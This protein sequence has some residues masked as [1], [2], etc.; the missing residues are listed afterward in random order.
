ML[1][2]RMAHLL[3]TIGHPSDPAADMALSADLLDEVARGRRGPTARL[4]T[5]GPTA[6]FGSLDRLRP[7]FPRAQESARAAGLTPVMRLAGGHAACY[8]EGS[9]VIEL[10]RPQARIVDGI[11]QRFEH[12]T[13]VLVAGLAALGVPVTVGE[14][15]G[16]YCPGRF[17][18]HLPDG[19]KVAG[20]AQRIVRGA[21]LTTAV[22]VV[23]GGATL[24]TRVER[25]Y[26]A[27]DL[28]VDPAAAGALED[29]HPD[30]T[31]PQVV[32]ALAEEL[33]REA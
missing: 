26:G 8:D 2:G 3:E 31:Q 29:R 10:I 9:V 20:V 33:R 1:P 7:G 15:P 5:P 28:P 27:L 6:A 21:S 4:Y 18:L 25:I 22:L 12:L 13:G 23:T 24:R 32:A 17:S 14:L 11:E 30:L 16:E 19:P